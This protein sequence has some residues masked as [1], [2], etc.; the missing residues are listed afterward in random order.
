MPVKQGQVRHHHQTSEHQHREQTEQPI[1]HHG[2][3]RLRFFVMRLAGRVV[4]FQQVS[5]GRSQQERIEKMR[6]ERNFSGA[7]QR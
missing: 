7:S 1:N 6:D 3:Y 4:S 2:H 5:A